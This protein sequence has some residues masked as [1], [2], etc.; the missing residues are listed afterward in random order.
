MTRFR[1]RALLVFAVLA[2]GSMWWPA[3][4]TAQLSAGEQAC[5]VAFTNSVARVGAAQGNIIADCL[6]RFASGSLIATRPEACMVSG[7]GTKLRK[8]AF[9]TDAAASFACAAV[10]PKFGVSRSA[11][12]VITAAGKDIELV[13]RIIGP[14]LDTALV[15]VSTDARCQVRVAASLQKCAATRMAEYTKC[16][17]RGMADGRVTDAPSLQSV[18]LGA[19]GQTQP[20]P[21][22][23]IA[24]QCGDKV[25][26]TIARYCAN[27]D[28]QRAFPPC[29]AS[30][31]RGV[32]SCVTRESACALCQ[33]L[34]SVNKL[35][36]DCDS[37]DDGDTTDGTC[38]DECADGIVQSGEGCDDGNKTSD[39]GCASDCSLE[40]GW[41]CTGQPSVCSHNCGNGAVDA[42]DGE[43]CDDGNTTSNDGCSSSCQIENC[44]NGQLD[45]GETCDDNNYSDSDGC[46]KTCQTEPG[47]LCTGEP[48]DCKFVCGNGTMDPGETCDD[49]N[50][51]AG[52]GCS[53]VCKQE[54][55]FLCSEVP[56]RCAAICGDGL[57]RTGEGCDDGNTGNGDGCSNDCQAETGYQCTGEPSVC[58]GICGDGLVRKSETCDDHNANNGDGCSSTCQQEAGWSCSGQPSVCAP[59]CGNRKVDLG[60][61]CDD[62][63]TSSD[64]D[65]C[66]GCMI[67]AGWACAGEPSTCAQTCGNGQR[68]AGEE[69]DDH[70][71]SN[72][73]GCSAGCLIEPGFACITQPTGSQCTRTCGNRMVQSGLGEEC[74]DGNLLRGD[75][76]DA[77]CKVEIG[78]SCTRSPSTCEETCGNGTVENNLGEQCDDGNLTNGDGCNDGCLT[79]PGWYCPPSNPNGCKQFD[80]VIDSP[81][82]GSFVDGNTV[83]VTGHYTELPGTQTSILVNGESP[84]HWNPA[85]RTFEHTL[86]LTPE[87][88]ADLINPIKVTLIN[89]ETGDDVRDR[90]VVVAGSSVRNGAFSPESVAL[91]L[92]ETGLASMQSLVA[93]L[94]TSGL[95]IGSLMPVGQALL[96]YQCFIDTGFLGCWGGA[97]LAISN[98]APS[99]GGVGLTIDSKPTVVGAD[100]AVNSLRVDV[101]LNGTGLVPNCGIRMTASRLSLDGDYSLEPAAVNPS[102][103]S[104]DL[105]GPMSTQF[106]GFKITFTSGI[107]SWPIIKQILEAVAP[108]LGVEKMATSAMGDFLKD[109]DGSGPQKAPVAEGIET[110]LEGVN[111]SGPVGEGVGLTFD[112]PMFEIAEDDSG[113]TIGADSR[114]T[115]S[116]GTGLGQCTPPPGTPVLAA[117]YSPY[118]P[119]P[120]FGPTTPILGAPYGLGI[121]ISTAGFNQ[122]LRGQ[123]ECG[124]MRSSLTEIDMDGPE[125][126]PASPITSD[127]LS[128]FV[129]EFAFLPSGTPMQIDLA[130]TLAPIMTNSAG[131]HGELAELLIG[132]L[133]INIVEQ[134]TGKI[135]LHG[136]FDASLGLNLAFKPDGSGLAIELSKPATSDVTITVIDNP[137]GTDERA[138]ETVLPNIMAPMIPSLAGALSGFPLPQFFGMSIQ[139]VEVSR[140]G[141]FLSLFA[142]LSAGS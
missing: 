114:F 124:L 29:K 123:T 76:C 54:N 134:A 128:A 6:K 62:G 8:A 61:Q 34:N 28:L 86:T 16:L 21:A 88:L 66:I 109:P 96:P 14:N 75:G 82:H 87:N 85:D 15:P 1:T 141:K 101:S 44:G 22:G 119:F 97:S 117:S 89:T 68:E 4:S 140:S 137:L 5:I 106:T 108:A 53:S 142:N 40:P 42:A 118:E 20:D 47:Y 7:D 72:G 102:H 104:V 122:L 46:S 98:P 93:S 63:N 70:N 56:S 18:C 49:G 12:A 110:A 24:T 136:A 13:R 74:D 92:N 69:C 57:L 10:T 51:T 138:V 84:I 77:D 48:S 127:L 2:L 43:T 125:G 94:A 116:V 139:G 52:D 132:Q 78:F 71:Q 39:D 64:H 25:A 60:E 113:I 120:T 3:A 115:V 73:D 80:V 30:D 107:C 58:T 41:S 23:R 59:N 35:S 112:A 38:G 50:K 32:V 65:G 133:G 103:V 17:R 33:V 9:Q 100:I 95:N 79:E 99:F 45:A 91:R 135:W 105:V 31:G 130:P 129:P 37:F 55:G 26:K 121:S 67:E 81:L 83:T 11:E 111:V 90:V 126:A 131:P 36:E 27:V 19:D